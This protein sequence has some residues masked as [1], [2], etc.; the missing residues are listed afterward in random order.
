MYD[1][2]TR[3]ARRAISPA[4][5]SYHATVLRE[6]GLLTTRRNGMSVQHD[7]T[8]LGSALLDGQLTL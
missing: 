8:A 2:R 7:L 4:S 5:A 3:P 6:A 1:H